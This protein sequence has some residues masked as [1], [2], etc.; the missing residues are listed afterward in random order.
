[1]ATAPPT[2][3]EAQQCSARAEIRNGDAFAL[4]DAVPSDSVDL[5]LTSPPYWGLRSYGTNPSSDILERWKA[6]GNSVTTAP[7]YGW[8]RDAGGILGLE[9]YP[10]WYV[11]HLVE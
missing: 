5:I 2:V 8:Y 9:P 10:S 3:I 7:A 4:I 1:M 11:E 6:I